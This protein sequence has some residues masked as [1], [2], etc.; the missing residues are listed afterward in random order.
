M[1]KLFPVLAAA[2]LFVGLSFAARAEDDKEVTKTGDGV[3]AKCSLKETKTCQNVVQVEEDGKTVKYYLA[4]ND[5]SKKYHGS[6]GICT[7]TV[8]TKVTGT[9]KKDG[10][11]MV[12]TATKIEKVAD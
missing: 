5:I 12:I 4:A 1:R 3:C 9:C 6:S 10:D 11:K 7:G 2:F 8:K